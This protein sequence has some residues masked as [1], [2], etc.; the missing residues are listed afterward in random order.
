M[1]IITQ[2]RRDEGEK[3]VA[4]QDSKGFWTIG[5]GICIDS[6]V[7]GAGITPEESIYLLNNRIAKWNTILYARL[8]YF[9]N[10]DPVRQAVLIDM[11]HNLGFDGLEKF[12]NFL[13]CMAQGDWNGAAGEMLDSLWAKQ[14]GDRAIRLAQQIKTGE[15][16]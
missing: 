10:L 12:T 6:R 8:P 5:I 3:F 15:W 4:Y 11:T 2:L 9:Q 14:V 7:P 13:H 16:V 1:D